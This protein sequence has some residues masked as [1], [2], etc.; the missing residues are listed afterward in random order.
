MTRRPDIAIAGATGSLTLSESGRIHRSLQFAQFRDGTATRSKPSSLLLFQIDLLT[1]RT[2]LI[3]RRAKRLA[4]KHLLS[5]GLKL[6]AAHFLLSH[7]EYQTFAC[8]FDV[9]GLIESP[10]DI[11]SSGFKLLLLAPTQHGAHFVEHF[12]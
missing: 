8:R 5:R 10:Q 3:G 4:A 6:T 9:I 11:G 12:L 2:T 1:V 7:S